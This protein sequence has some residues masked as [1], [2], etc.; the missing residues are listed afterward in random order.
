MSICERTIPEKLLIESTE[1]PMLSKL[2]VNIDSTMVRYGIEYEGRLVGFFTPR[3]DTHDGVQYWRTGTIYIQPAY[4]GKGLAKQ[5]VQEFFRDKPK[6]L[7]YILP[8]NTPSMKT[9]KSAGFKPIKKT[10]HPANNKV[11]W[12]M[13]KD[14]DPSLLHKSW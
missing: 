5:A 9:Y 6:G 3:L 4:R 10:T 14:E 13:I 2:S 1:D 11:Y 7:A 12:I 8:T